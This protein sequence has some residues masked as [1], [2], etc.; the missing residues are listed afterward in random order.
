MAQRKIDELGRVIIPEEIRNKTGISCRNTVK[1]YEDNGKIILEKFL[2]ACKICGT[3]RNVNSEI[4]V[5][6]ECIERIKQL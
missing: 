4:C 2:P 5:C 3:E 6:R 1:I